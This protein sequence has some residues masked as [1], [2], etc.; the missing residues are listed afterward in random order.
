MGYSF[1]LMPPNM[2]EN[3]DKMLLVDMGSFTTQMEI[4]TKAIGK[5]TN[6]MGLESINTPME[7]SISANGRTIS[8][9]GKG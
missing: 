3:G 1:G 5:M 8:S 6:L 7:L 9:M 2:K 4:Y